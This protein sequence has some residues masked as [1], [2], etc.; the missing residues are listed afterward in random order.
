MPKD[1]YVTDEGFSIDAIEAFPYNSDGIACLVVQSSEDRDIHLSEIKVCDDFSTDDPHTVFQL[2]SWIYSM[3]Q[4]SNREIYIAHSGK[5]LRSGPH[6]AP[7]IVLEV[8]ADMTKLCASS[9]GV[10]IVGLNGY[11]AHFDGGALSEF[12]VPDAGNIYFVSEAP[13]GTVFACGDAGGLYR[14]DGNAWTRI[15]LPT[16][17]DIH[18][19]LAKGREW[20]LLAG[21][22]GLCAELNGAN[23]QFFSPPDR[24]HYRA[25]AEYKGQIFVGAGHLGLE[26]VKDGA[27]VPFKDNVYTY[28]LETDGKVLVA[29]GL[30]EVARYDGTAWLAAEFT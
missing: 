20:V 1:K 24:R 11:V 29:T 2:K 16:G 22:D 13:D 17:S 27:V 26:V 3:W 28:N 23:L 6:Q 15:D 8:K 9:R 5:K 7:A 21:S 30:N 18:R 10:W 12:P 19:I 25:I 14:L 4:V